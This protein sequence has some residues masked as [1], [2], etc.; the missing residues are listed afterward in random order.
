M[1][2][3]RHEGPARQVVSREERPD[4]WRR[5]HP[6]DGEAEEDRLVTGNVRERGRER[7]FVAGVAL[8][9]R[10]TDR[11]LVVLR[12]SFGGPDLEQVRVECPTNLPRDDPRVAGAREVGD[13]DL[14]RARGTLPGDGGT[15]G[16][17]WYDRRG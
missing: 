10:L 14:P 6:P 5:G 2:D 11:R 12:I 7:R 9:L 1:R 17:D 8:P 4:H 13:Q 15:G 3:E 16:N